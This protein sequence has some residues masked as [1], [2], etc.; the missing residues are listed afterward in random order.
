MK[1]I[2]SLAASLGLVA[3]MLGITAGAVAAHNVSKVVGTVDC[4][5]AYSITVTGD[6]YGGVILTVSLGGTNVYSQ[7]QNGTSA[8]RTFGPFTGTGAT[9]GEAIGAA[10]SDGSS[11]TGTLVANP[12]VCTA[13]V[14]FHKVIDSD[15]TGPKSASDFTITL[16][17]S[18]TYSGTDGQTASVAPGTY[19]IGETQIAG[20]TSEFGGSCYDTS[21]QTTTLTLLAGHS[22]LCG[23]N[24]QWAPPLPTITLNQCV[25]Y[26]GGNGF[27]IAGLVP[28]LLVLVTPVSPSGQ[29][30]EYAS[31]DSYPLG[32]GSYTWQAVDASGHTYNDP[33]AFVIGSCPAPPVVKVTCGGSATFSG[34]LP[35]YDLVVDN[36]T[37]IPVDQT[38]IVGPLTEAVGQHEFSI[39]GYTG[40]FSIT[41]C[42]RPPTCEQLGTCP[43]PTPPATPT[44]TPVATPTPTPVATPTATPVIATPRP[45]PPPTYTSSGLADSSTPSALVLLLLASSAVIGA[46]AYAVRRKI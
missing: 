39:A 30:T 37:G 38:G 8:V 11:T 27:T 18:Q 41:A 32:P 44:P 12:A 17:G 16:T 45:T 2:L 46:A 29:G 4:S 3:L 20:Y 24:N 34:L 10:T 25:T 26:N 33:V 1:R 23:F 35:G 40:A 14:T 43:T 15:P 7:A 5:G 31:N 13:T 6:V 22:Y 9:A 36:A 28:G 42:P 19:A 21:L